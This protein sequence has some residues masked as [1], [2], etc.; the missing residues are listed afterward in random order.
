[1]N[2]PSCYGH[3]SYSKSTVNATQDTARNTIIHLMP[4]QRTSDLTSAAQ[5]DVVE[6]LEME[7][8]EPFLV[9]QELGGA[10]VPTSGTDAI[11]LPHFAGEW[12][13]PG[14][15]MIEAQTQAAYNGACMVNGRDQACSFL[16][17]PNPT[18][19]A[20]VHTFTTDSTILNNF[21]HYSSE[22]QSQVKYHQYPIS[23]SFLISSYEDFKKRRNRLRNQED[24]LLEM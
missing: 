13:G 9:R 18:G 16:R 23:S 2:K 22:S 4:F 10:A 5:P 7:E 12:K 11:A 6:G 15:N 1:M 14:K 3:P 21:A 17:N 19:H 24:Y 8:F 20:Y